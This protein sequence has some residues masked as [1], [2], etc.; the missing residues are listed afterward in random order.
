MPPECTGATTAAGTVLTHCCQSQVR[1]RDS[2][3]AR[4][5]SAVQSTCYFPEDPGSI[6]STM[7]GGSQLRVT[8]GAVDLTLLSSLYVLRHT[9][10][11]HSHRRTHTHIYIYNKKTSLASYLS[12]KELDY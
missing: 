4:D 10:S 2:A 7:L 1:V 8:A 12:A 11:I 5:G 3:R 9:H 6:P